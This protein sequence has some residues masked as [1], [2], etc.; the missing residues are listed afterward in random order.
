[1]EE[2]K[3]RIKERKTGRERPERKQRKKNKEKENTNQNVQSWRE[4]GSDRGLNARLLVRK[5]SAK[6]GS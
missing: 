4:I 1:L 5:N 3:K 2:K 6:R